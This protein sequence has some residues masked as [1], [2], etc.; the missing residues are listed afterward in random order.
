MVPIKRI[1]CPTDYSACAEHAFQYAAHWA[2]LFQAELH[3][4]HVVE[5]PQPS[6][7]M[8][9]GDLATPPYM[10]P[11]IPVASGYTKEVKKRLDGSGITIVDAEVQDYSAVDGILDYVE[12]NKIDLIVMG[13]HGRRGANRLLMGSISEEVVRSAACPVCTIREAVSPEFKLVFDR[14]L[15]PIDFS[16][17]SREAVRIAK[18]WAAREKAHLLILNVMEEVQLP[19]VYQLETSFV[20]TP[21]TRSRMEGEMEE[22]YASIDGPDVPHSVYARFGYPARTIREVVLNRNVQ[23]VIMGTHGRTGIP[24]MLLGSVAEKVIRTSPC[25][26]VAFHPVHEAA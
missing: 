23:L 13:T 6:I 24:R 22:W 25:P 17:Y 26:V 3:M 18:E 16:A 19:G 8:F 12:E 2:T 9:G 20:N 14:I 21:E 5:T 10:V 7:D 15:V 1:L 11:T 4:M